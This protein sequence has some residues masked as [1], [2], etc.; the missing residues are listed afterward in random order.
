M[1][2]QQKLAALT[3]AWKQADR[4]SPERGKFANQIMIL[5]I[6]EMLKTSK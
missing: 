6:G 5:E 4:N 3:L 2:Y 1:T